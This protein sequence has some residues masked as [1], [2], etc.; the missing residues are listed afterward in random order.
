MCDFRVATEKINKILG[1]GDK[2]RKMTIGGVTS[3]GAL[4]QTYYGQVQQQDK[5]TSGAKES[6]SGDQVKTSASEQIKNLYSSGHSVQQI[7][8]SMGLSTNVVDEYLG[9]TTATE[10]ALLSAAA[11]K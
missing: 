10:K 4:E 8:S 5:S 9:I 6:D 2:K 7:A 3:T 11:Q 1:P